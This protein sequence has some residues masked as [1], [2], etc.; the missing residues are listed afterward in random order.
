MRREPRYYETLE[1]A[2]EIAD[3]CAKRVVSLTKV[4]ALS[5]A[6]KTSAAES[7][8]AMRA[9]SGI[10]ECYMPSQHVIRWSKQITKQREELSGHEPEAA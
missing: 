6:L 5:D 7:A 1:L 3:E 9:I 10:A 4:R 8:L 2:E